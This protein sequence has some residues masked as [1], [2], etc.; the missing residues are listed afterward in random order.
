MD[1]YN[2]VRGTTRV[3]G[4]KSD[5]ATTIHQKERREKQDSVRFL[6]AGGTKQ[7]LNRP[8][9]RNHNEIRLHFVVSHHHFDQRAAAFPEEGVRMRERHF[10]V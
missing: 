4:V 3:I 8:V 1:C 2:V 5:R 7:S 6:K 10:E 9:M